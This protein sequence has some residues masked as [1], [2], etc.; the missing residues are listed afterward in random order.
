M[1]VSGF[2][3]C[4]AYNSKTFKPAFKIFDNNYFLGIFDFG[5]KMK[6]NYYIGIN[7]GTLDVWLQAGCGVRQDGILFFT[8]LCP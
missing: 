5:A 6:H 1:G 3:G 2:G 8:T 4:I 7:F